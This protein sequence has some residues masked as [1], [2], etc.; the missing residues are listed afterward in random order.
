[1]TV[2]IYTRFSSNNQTEM[3]TAAQV[4]ACREFAE[5]SGME[6]YK[7]YSDEAV[8][9]T[10][11]KTDARQQYQKLLDYDQVELEFQPEALKAVADRAVDRN[12]GARG[13]RAILE[14]VMTSVMYEVPSDPTI[15]RVVITPE[16]VTGSGQPELH[17]N[18]ERTQ[19][20]ALGAAALRAQ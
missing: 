5:H 1:M 6:I 12:I 10:E 15:V 9:G 11:E 14:E 2:D 4:R 3:S 19:R 17:R 13:L 7:I 16:C 18:P 8:S 20:P